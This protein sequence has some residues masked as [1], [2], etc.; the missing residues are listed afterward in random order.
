[1]KA[2]GVVAPSLFPYIPPLNS[3]HATPHH[4]L[5]SYTIYSTSIPKNL[6]EPHPLF[7]CAKI[8]LQKD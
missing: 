1:M 2:P 8:Q 6:A 3:A 7:L 4:P 5:L